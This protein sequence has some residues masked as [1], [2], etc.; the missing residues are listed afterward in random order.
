VT[1]STTATDSRWWATSPCTG[2]RW[3]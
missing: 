2:P 1:S 3:R